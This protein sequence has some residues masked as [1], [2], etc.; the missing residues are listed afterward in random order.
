MKKANSGRTHAV[1]HEH[2][3]RWSGAVEPQPDAQRVQR[4]QRLVRGADKSSE[5]LAPRPVESPVPMYQKKTVLLC[6]S[7]TVSRKQGMPQLT[8]SGTE[9]TSRT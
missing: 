3:F 5:Q 8:A 1:G 9:R 6:R 4:P 7:T 2:A